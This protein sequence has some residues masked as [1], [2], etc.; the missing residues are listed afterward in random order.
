MFKKCCNFKFEKEGL[1]ALLFN[2]VVDL[3]AMVPMVK[4]MVSKVL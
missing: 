1:V 2:L 3:V 4:A